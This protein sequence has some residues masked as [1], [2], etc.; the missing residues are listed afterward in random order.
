MEEN[1]EVKNK[2]ISK[3][4]K[5]KYRLVILN[6]DTF[7]ERLSLSLTPINVFTW[8]GLILIVFIVSIYAL[9]AY[10]PM[11]EYIPG[12]ADTNT[13]IQAQY[14]AKKADSLQTAVIQQQLWIKNIGAILKGEDPSALFDKNDSVTKI[15]TSNIQYK[16]SKEDSI[17]RKEV[18]KEERFNINIS[19]LEKSYSG[20]RSF[21][22]FTPISG[23]VS[24]SF[25]LKEKHYGV[26]IAAKENEAV[27]AV[28]DGTVIFTAW[29]A[30][31]GNVIQ[32]Q[33][34][35]NLI[36]VYKHNSVLL[37]KMGDKVKAGEAIG[38]VGNSGKHTTGFHL[39]FELWYNG[40]PID[41]QDYIVF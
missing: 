29:T 4:L 10:T 41:P 18:E 35:N 23:Q 24:A 22:F 40:S 6:H 37:K 15:S 33:H 19:D 17:L 34:S 16:A 12:Y 21:F 31:T 30:E 36:S 20:I 28:I 3:R 9:I 8:G 2:K 14:A 5:N 25:N 7:E 1:R 39:H 38:I 11:R 27:F 26:D 13:R 32:V